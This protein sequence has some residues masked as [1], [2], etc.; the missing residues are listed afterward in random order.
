MSTVLLICWLALIVVSY[1]GAIYTLDK[2]N[3]L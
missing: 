3:L 1:R 2:L